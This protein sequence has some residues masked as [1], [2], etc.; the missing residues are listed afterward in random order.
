MFAK[1]LTPM[2]KA[3]LVLMLAAI[4]V[5]SNAQTR[6]GALLGYASKFSQPA[7]GGNLEFFI[8]EKISLSPNLLLY[9]PESHN[10]KRWGYFEIN[11]N[12]NYYFYS[13]DVFEFYGLG[14]LNYTHVRFKDK[15]F[16][17]NSYVDGNLNLNLGGGINFKIGHGFL[18]FSE[19]RYVIGG[20]NQ[21][22][23]V[24]G[25]RFTVGN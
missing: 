23:V 1:I 8:D 7:L 15:T 6:V 5:S 18:P 10:N 2:K 4:V 19:V 14:G 13:K 25:L 16:T 9:F 11:F 12:G 3:L 21:V 24:A 22:V 17:D 20:T